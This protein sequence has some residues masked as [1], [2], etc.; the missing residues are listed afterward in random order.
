MR[1]LFRIGIHV[2]VFGLVYRIA[3]TH[4]FHGEAPYVVAALAT[5][6]LAHLM[7]RRH[8]WR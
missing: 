2:V 6:L 4:G 8:R 7:Y 3:R 1:W 5:G